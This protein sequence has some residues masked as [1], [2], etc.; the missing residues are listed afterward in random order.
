MGTNIVNCVLES[1]SD[2]KAPGSLLMAAT[3][4]PDA[5]DPAIRRAGRLDRTI[6]IEKP[7]VEDLRAIFR[8]HLKDALATTDLTAVA[9]CGRRRHRRRHRIL[10][11]KSEVQGAPRKA[12]AADR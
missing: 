5:I 2:V 3:N 8:F 9:V 10:V 7:S 11:S 1:M 12:R 6:T 4:F